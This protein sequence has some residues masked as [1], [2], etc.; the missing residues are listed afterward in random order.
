MP[1]GGAGTD[2]VIGVLMAARVIDSS[3]ASAVKR[4]TDSEVVFFALDSAGRARIAA[5][6][7]PG[8]QNSRRSSRSRV[9]R[10]PGPP[11]TAP[12]RGA[13]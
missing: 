6:S 12:R 13:T 11:P 8:N 2:V 3:L 7:L 9:R 4:A 10:S 1:I 5:S